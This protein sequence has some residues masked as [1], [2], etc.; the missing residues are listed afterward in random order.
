MK[1][2]SQYF[3]TPII[4][5]AILVE[6]IKAGDFPSFTAK[7]RKNGSYFEIYNASIL[8]NSQNKVEWRAKEF[9]LPVSESVP[10]NSLLNQNWFP[11]K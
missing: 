10:F 1:R 6:F 7:K 3:N 8:I 11:F 2:I 5:G 9:L 4:I